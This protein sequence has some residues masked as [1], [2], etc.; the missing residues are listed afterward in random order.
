MFY[1]NTILFL[2]R[3]IELKSS[4]KCSLN[5]F[6]FNNRC[7]SDLNRICNKG[8]QI[9]KTKLTETFE[10]EMDL[11]NHALKNVHKETRDIKNTN[12]VHFDLIKCKV[13]YSHF[14]GHRY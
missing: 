13:H 11:E 14:T 5:P 3:G 10:L 8:E 6:Y 2:I 1:L 9:R 7:I 4:S 12:R